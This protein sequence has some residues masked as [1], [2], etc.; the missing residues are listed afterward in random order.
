MLSLITAFCD[1]TMSEPLLDVRDV[2]CTREWSQKIFSGVN[3]SVN[4]GDVAVLQGKSG[5]G[6][7]VA[8]LAMDSPLT[9]AGR[10]RYSSVS[11][12]STR[13]GVRYYTAGGECMRQLEYLCL[14]EPRFSSKPTSYGV[15][16]YTLT[17]PENTIPTAR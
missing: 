9:C 10:P 11:P 16:S 3:F 12:T 2:S 5:S 1:T 14:N 13:T 8:G 7:E 4:Q 17:L 6:Y 15:W